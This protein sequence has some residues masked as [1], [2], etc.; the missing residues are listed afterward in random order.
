MTF[1]FRKSLEWLDT[2][3]HISILEECEKELIADFEKMNV[4]DQRRIQCYLNQI[5]TIKLKAK[6]MQE[7]S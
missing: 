7:S 3:F 1:N 5:Y 4:P 6:E 2:E